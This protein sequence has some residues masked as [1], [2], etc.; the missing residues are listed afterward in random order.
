MKQKNLTS[1]FIATTF[2][3]AFVL[4][5]VIISFIDVKAIGPN[6]SKVGLATL[7]GAI[8]ELIGVH[9][10]L[11][12][13]TDWLGLVPIAVA[14]GFAILGLIQWIK[15]KNILKVDF[16]VL[17]LG[18][19]YIV[20]F[21][22]YIL[23][24]YVVINRRPVFINGYLEA[25]YPSSTTMLVTCVMPTTIMQLTWR[26]KNDA[27]KKILTVLISLFIAFMVIGRFISGV[28]WFTDIFGGLLYSVGIVAL[29]YF[30]CIKLTIK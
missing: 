5:T 10:A 24:E 25:S 18:C 23:F 20:V 4:W 7:N 27:L 13:I 30:F 14:L 26:I 3:L 16:D 11:Y 19:F 9:F 22:T 1:L 21:A 8:K 17:I 15:R 2:L 28:H 12:V 6:G 29:Y